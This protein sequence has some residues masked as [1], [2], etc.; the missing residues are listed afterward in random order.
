VSRG[1]QADSASHP[2]QAGLVNGLVVRVVAMAKFTEQRLR[3]SR[4]LRKRTRSVIALLAKRSKNVRSMVQLRLMR[5][6]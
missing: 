2:R 6:V 5:L 3:S 1:H 4:A